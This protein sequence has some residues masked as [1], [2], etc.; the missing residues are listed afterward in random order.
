MKPPLRTRRARGPPSRPKPRLPPAHR[1][2]RFGKHY[3]AGLQAPERVSNVRMQG[4]EV[5][6]QSV[7]QSPGGYAARSVSGDVGCSVAATRER[8]PQLA[9]RAV[10]FKHEGGVWLAK[11]PFVETPS[12]TPPGYPIFQARTAS[13]LA[14]PPT[15]L[16]WWLGSGA[17][18]NKTPRPWVARDLRGRPG[19][20]ASSPSGL[21]L[22]RP[23]RIP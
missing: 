14:P 8:R 23:S 20:A 15:C 11:D 7:E 10:A 9:R 12:R 13:Q 22:S 5:S 4:S 19:F 16:R 2:Y 6:D 18:R 1:F 21:P 17:S 3:R